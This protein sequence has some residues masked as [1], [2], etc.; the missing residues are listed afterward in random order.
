MPT[1]AAGPWWKRFAWF[2]LLWALGVASV[3]IVAF[4]LRWWLHP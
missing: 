4:V 1:D 3:G 2:L